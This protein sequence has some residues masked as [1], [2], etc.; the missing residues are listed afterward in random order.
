MNQTVLPLSKITEAKAN[1][2]Q[3]FD[4]GQ[5]AELAESIKLYGV[6]QPIGVL[7]T[8][9]KADKY[10]VAYGARR[11]RA[12]KL[13]GLKDIPALV[14]TEDLAKSAAEIR[15]VE[16]VQ[17]AALTPLDEAA[18]IVALR[19]QGL[20]VREIAKRLGKTP[21]YVARRANLVNLAMPLKKKLL[22]GKV[23]ADY[24]IRH[25]ELI[26]LLPE[27]EQHLQDGEAGAI[28]WLEEEVAACTNRLGIAPWDLED[29]TIEPK[30]GACSR[31]PKHSLHA[32]GLFDE[33]DDGEH[34]DLEKAVCLDSPC[35]TQK[36]QAWWRERLAALRA[37]HGGNLLLVR[38]ANR[39]QA[40]DRHLI[41]A[42]EVAKAVAAHDWK[43][44]KQGAKGAQP[45]LVVSGDGVGTTLWVQ[46]GRGAGTSSAAKKAKKAK[47]VEKQPAEP[48]DPR[49]LRRERLAR[50][51]ER[52]A[53][54]TLKDLAE[55]ISKHQ[56]PP[57]SILI[58]AGRFGMGY[59]APLRKIAWKRLGK[60][61]GGGAEEK[62]AHDLV[63]G[64]RKMIWVAVREEIRKEL[65]MLNN[66]RSRKEGL[67]IGTT[68]AGILFDQDEQALA[69]LA[70]EAIPTP[71]NLQPG[72]GAKKTPAKK[73]AKAPRKA[74]AKKGA[75]S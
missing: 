73:K 55:R 50:L 1:P 13:A 66:P 26:S 49:K 21:S 75:K 43:K 38:G 45:A 27:D 7:A 18:A 36:L 42:K 10:Q 9:G 37:E 2:R 59:G 14:L 16:N 60:V 22:D 71:K 24:S 69:K 23:S 54:W 51:A 47:P 67:R 70:E 30:A 19:E 61:L 48:V 62:E 32:P 17:R 41:P 72:A 20:E 40:K 39:F 52:R 68:L 44:S 6:L 46:T 53:S 25:L 11:L 5:L 4:D 31:C 8:A 65:D 33:S 28:E 29:E 64:A 57:Y 63:A 58:L 34:Q 35:W 15:L 3:T 56:D 74:T 12:A